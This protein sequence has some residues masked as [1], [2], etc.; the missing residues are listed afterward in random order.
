MWHLL[1]RAIRR[2]IPRAWMRGG[3]VCASAPQM[4]ALLLFSSVSVVF[5]GCSSPFPCEFF[6]IRPRLHKFLLLISSLL[7]VL[8][9]RGHLIHTSP[10]P[11]CV[12]SRP[13]SLLRRRM[14]F[15]VARIS[16]LG[17][18]DF[19]SFFCLTLFCYSSFTDSVL[20]ASAQRVP[21]RSA[22]NLL[23]A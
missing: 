1:L 13:S 3:C 15:L 23:V 9:P 21:L 12:G 7:R 2:V 18:F 11:P 14:S 22:S 10:S 20:W 17:Q 19:I 4:T 16:F 5:C 6:A 8:T